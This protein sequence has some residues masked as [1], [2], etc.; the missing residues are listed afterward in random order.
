MWC[1]VSGSGSVVSELMWWLEQGMMHHLDQTLISHL[2]GKRQI[3]KLLK[4]TKIKREG[5]SKKIVIS[6]VHKGHK[7][8][9]RVRCLS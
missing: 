8:E 3:G 5:E 7:E 6:H 1:D 9:W 4:D 2:H